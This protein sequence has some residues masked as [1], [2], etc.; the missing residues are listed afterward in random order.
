M[1]INS[2]EFVTDTPQTHRTG[3]VIAKRGVQNPHLRIIILRTLALRLS[4]LRSDVTHA[5]VLHLI[6]K[7]R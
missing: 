6:S 5:S 3:I 4:Y 2:L 7:V 1:R